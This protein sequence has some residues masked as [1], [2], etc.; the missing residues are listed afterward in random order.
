VPVLFDDDMSIDECR[1]CPG[2]VSDGVICSGPVTL[3][4][5][6]NKGKLTIDRQYRDEI[7]DDD[8]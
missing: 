4:R 3:T 1:M 5:N 6:R 8:N 7:P 2:L